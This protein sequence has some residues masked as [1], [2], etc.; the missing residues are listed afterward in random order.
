MSSIDSTNP[1]VDSCSYSKYPVPPN[2]AF[3]GAPERMALLRKL[4]SITNI[5]RLLLFFGT[6]DSSWSLSTYRNW[7]LKLSTDGQRNEN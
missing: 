5:S 7:V 6:C 2:P 4:S 3:Y 1:P